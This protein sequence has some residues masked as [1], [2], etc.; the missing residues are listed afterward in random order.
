M[1]V[2]Y[3]RLRPFPTLGT[4]GTGSV[5]SAHRLQKQIAP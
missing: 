2:V 4:Q 3:S 1:R 5:P